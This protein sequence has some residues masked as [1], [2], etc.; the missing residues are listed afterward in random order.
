MSKRK[1]T[2]RS[3]AW[4]SSAFY[5]IGLTS[6]TEVF[7]AT[8]RCR[9]GTR[10]TSQ[11]NLFSSGHPQRRYFIIDFRV[12]RIWFSV[13][14][15]FFIIDLNSFRFVEQCFLALTRVNESNKSSF[16]N[17]VR[18]NFSIKMRVPH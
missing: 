15:I 3:F 1:Y 18:S 12:F 17:D 11:A 6:T 9:F 5:V 10:V 4:V 2:S 14:S 7:N 8:T 16:T 13:F